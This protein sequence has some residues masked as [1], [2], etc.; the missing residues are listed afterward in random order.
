MNKKLIWLIGGMGSGKSTQRR[1]LCNAFRETEPKEIKGNL[2]DDAE[3]MFTSFGKTISCIG[4]VKQEHNG[5]ISMCDGL[6]SVFGSLKK[7]GGLHSVDVALQHSDIVVLEG[8][9]TSP[10]WGELLKST[11]ERY[12]AE[13]H[14]VHLYMTYE[15][16]FNRVRQRQ[17]DK[18]KKDGGVMFINDHKEHH[19]TDRVIESLIGKCRQFNNCYD[20]LFPLTYIN[21]VKIL[22]GNK[23]EEEVFEDII[24]GCF[25]N[26]I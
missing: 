26:D 22:C 4:K 1:L 10:S 17:Y 12:G 9:Q 7:L 25:A 18:L 5:D 21:K 14:L 13:F 16:N 3:Y 24:Q 8:S 20:K 6:D 2:T 19:L 11:I 23:T 15:E